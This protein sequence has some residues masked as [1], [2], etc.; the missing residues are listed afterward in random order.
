MNKILKWRIFGCFW[1]SSHSWQNSVRHALS[2]NDCFVKIPRPSGEAGKGCYWTVHPRAVDMFENGSSMRRNRK[3]VD[4]SRIRSG[5][6]RRRCPNYLKLGTA[7]HPSCRAIKEEYTCLSE[8][9]VTSA[10]TARNTSTAGDDYNQASNWKIT[11]E[12]VTNESPKYIWPICTNRAA[13]F[14]SSNFE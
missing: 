9:A 10:G 13:T 6:S 5:S 8:T 2:F 4:E 12:C 1:K 11:G 3:F 7:K 14:E